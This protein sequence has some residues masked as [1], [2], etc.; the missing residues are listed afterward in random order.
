VS[1]RVVDFAD[2]GF[3]AARAIDVRDLPAF[4]VIDDK[5]GSLYA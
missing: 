2:L 3:E 1:E 4:I 5:A